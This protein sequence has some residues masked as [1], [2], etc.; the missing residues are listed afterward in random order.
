MQAA[1]YQPS[2]PAA[3]KKPL[4]LEVEQRPPQRVAG[5]T[6]PGARLPLVATAACWMVVSLLPY[7]FLTYMPV[8]PSRHTYLAGVG[9]SLIVG[10]GFI[11]LR[12]R[13]GCRRSVVAGVALLV[14]L[15]N[16]SYLWIRKQRQYIERAE[17]TELLVENL[18]DRQGRVEVYCFP[19]A[20]NTADLA[21]TMRLG[22]QVQPLVAAMGRP[23]SPHDG[24][25]T[26][27]GRQQ[28]QP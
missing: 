9:L 18:R 4:L 11:S 5:D 15:H 14:L 13:P 10:A 28:Y 23:A 2:R 19:Y 25:S 26:C 24:P 27:A 22:H 16:F 21:V 7:S 1:T 12:E 8:V 6:E 20:P 3:A 17:P